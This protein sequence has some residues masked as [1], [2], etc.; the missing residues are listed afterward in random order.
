MISTRNLA[1]IPEIEALTKLT[2]SL[3]LLDAIMCP[4]WEYRYYSFNSQWGANEMMASMRDGS[5]DEL[6]ILFN[7]AG[8]IFKGF[9]H[10]SPMSAWAN[11]ASRIW[12]GVLDSVPA[13]F[14]EFLSE[15]AFSMQNTTF[16]IWR[17]FTDNAWHTGEINYPAGEDP[18]GSISLLYI[19]DGEPA[20]YQKWAERYY[21]TTIALYAIEHIYRHELVTDD[22]IAALNP[23]I[24][25]QA[26]APDLAEISYSSGGRTA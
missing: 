16:C 17:K 21:E 2:Q 3:A 18:D 7:S 5:G 10:E 24:S 12:P 26:L 19:F 14:K 15:S 8:A 9:A 20:T 4:E 25:L 6:F 13:E 22:V 1:A 11:E 23:N